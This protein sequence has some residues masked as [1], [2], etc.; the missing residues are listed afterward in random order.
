MNLP[1]SINLRAA[2]R[3]VCTVAAALLVVSG[4]PF[5]NGGQALAAQ[6]SS[7]S[8]QLSDSATSASSVTSGVGSG[9]NVT[10]RVQFT[11]S[12]TAQSLVIDFCQEDPIIGD[13]CTGPAGMSAASAAISTVSGETDITSAGWTI[14]PGASRVKLAKAT[15]NTA[16][17]GTHTF[18]LTGITNPSSAACTSPSVACTFYA[19]I[20]TYSNTTFGTPTA[21]SSAT[22]PGSY[23][24]Y[25][26]IALSTTSVIT[27]TARV[28]EQITFCVTKSNPSAWTTHDCS[29]TSIASATACS[30]A[31]CLPAV[32]IGHGSPTPVIDAN[33]ID[34]SAGPYPNGTGGSV[35]P[36]GGDL[37]T[38][39]STNA[40]HGAVVNIHTSTAACSSNAGGLSADAGATCAIPPINA[41]AGTASGMT[42][43]T[44][45][46][47]LYVANS[48]LDVGG[49]GSLT[50]TAAYHNGSHTTIPT[51]AT[52]GD[53]FFGWDTTT[54]NNNVI[55]TFG[56][57]MGSTAAPCYRVDNEYVFG[58][59][60]SL[61][62]PAGIYQANM[63]MIATGTF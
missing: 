15:G 27:I 19:R 7:R 54:A 14:T 18:D 28:Q 26:G 49:T 33:T 29:D 30:G 34:T 8:I 4:L 6:L 38:Q 43:G 41:G 22:A 11:T 58:A 21:Y 44:A 31:S 52:T 23:V 60:A 24:D 5:L 48:T 39:L 50:P 12:N 16:A 40:T 59:T 55:S 9:T 51:G 62:T 1:F 3:I 46:F 56:S 53:L 25:G 36:G 10:Y 32:A 42:A 47:G 57:T 13:T 63:S 17:V 2:G 37:F 35:Q 61:T 20:Y 45:A